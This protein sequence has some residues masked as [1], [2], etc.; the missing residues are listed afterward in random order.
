MIIP[1]M[2]L[3]IFIYIYIDI[4][5][6]IYMYDM[7]MFYFPVCWMIIQNGGKWLIFFKGFFFDGR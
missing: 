2:I 6:Y 7:T 1:Y 4:D 3:Y 5:I